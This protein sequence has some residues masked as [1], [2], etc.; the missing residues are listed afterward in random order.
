MMVDDDRVNEFQIRHLW[1]IEVDSSKSQ[2]Y[3]KPK[4]IAPSSSENSNNEVTDE[5][6]NASVA[7]MSL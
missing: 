6:K 3:N 1:D 4:K 2:T 7:Y 5:M